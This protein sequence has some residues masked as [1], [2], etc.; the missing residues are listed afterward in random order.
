M[1]TILSLVLILLSVAVLSY[2]LGG[3]KKEGFENVMMNNRI[4]GHNLTSTGLSSD[5]LGPHMSPDFNGNV[6]PYPQQS[7]T[8]EKQCQG[9]CVQPDVLTPSDLLPK[10]DPN[11]LWNV[12]NPPVNGSLT[13]KNFLESAYHFGINT[14]SGA[15]KNANR[16]LR[17][18]PF[19]QPANPS[20]VPWGMATIGP[21]TNRRHFEIGEN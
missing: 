13:D 10:P 21:D 12:T 16:Q 19:I 17:S 6:L 1:S 2:L 20:A 4:Q 18:D 9:S 3:M 11:S 7:N 8:Y 5:N 15:N 14:Q